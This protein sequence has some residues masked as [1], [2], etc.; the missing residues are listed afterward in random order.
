MSKNTNFTGPPILKPLF[1]AGNADVRKI[2]EQH[3][4]EHYVNKFNTRRHLTVMLFSVTERVKIIWIYFVLR[5]ACIIFV[6]DKL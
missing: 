2:A 1:F 5:S 4:V 3:E 6:P